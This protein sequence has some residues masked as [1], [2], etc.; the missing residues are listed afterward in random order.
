MSRLPFKGFP[1]FSVMWAGQFVSLIGTSMT[2][3]ALTIWA[4][5]TTGSATVLALVGFFSFAPA[6]LFSPLAGVLV[7]RWPRKSVL[8]ISDAGAG[9]ATLILLILA[10]TGNLAIWHLFLAGA[11]ASTFESFQFPAFSAAITT[12]VNKEQ[13]ARTSA[14]R[15]V[16]DSASTIIAPIMAGILLT[17]IDLAGIMFIDAVTFVIAMGTLAL[18]HIPRLA[19]SEVSAK[20]QANLKQ[21]ILYGFGYIWRRPSLLGLQLIFTLINLLITMAFILLAPMILGATKNSELSLGT[22]QMAAG[23]GGLTGGLLLSI[24]GGP[25]RK[26]HG[27]LFGMIC[28]GLLGQT[29][30]GF[31]QALWT[32]ALGAFLMMFSFPIVNSSS[33]AIWQVKVH[34]SVQG[35]VFSVRR[36]IAQLTAPIAMLLAGPLADRLFE[37]A[38]MPA[39]ALAPLFGGIIGTA[40]GSG[41]RLIFVITG[42]LVM[43][44]GALG[45]AIPVVR[46]IETILPDHEPDTQVTEADETGEHFQE[47]AASAQL[48]G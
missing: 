44:V 23:I 24:W 43:I 47:S 12:M 25:R 1:G 42:F 13:Y 36:L 45:Y 39:G 35:R 17:S 40:P 26:I 10:Q 32:W 46:D 48:A 27:V 6:V 28:S 33:Q 22:V 30:I 20:K 41:I 18:V 4:F 37:P 19:K 31:G 16:A 15:S 8:I 5:Q 34:P 7:D 21:E 38:M 9:F 14:M 29:L 11:I 3:F 2:R